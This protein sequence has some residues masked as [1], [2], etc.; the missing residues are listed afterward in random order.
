M[1]TWELFALLFATG[2]KWIVYTYMVRTIKI[3]KLTY[4]QKMHSRK[5]SCTKD[6]NYIWSFVEIQYNWT[7]DLIGAC[8]KKTYMCI[9]MNMCVN[10]WWL[11]VLTDLLW[12]PIASGHECH[13]ILITNVIKLWLEVSSDCAIC[14]SSLCS[15]A[16]P[17]LLADHGCEDRLV[18]T[19]WDKGFTQQN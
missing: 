8:Q 18:S 15:R 17:T 1:G 3:E 9:N 16:W 2:G 19:D 12:V 5:A 4:C 13:L 7:I 10:R 6:E 11:S 14:N